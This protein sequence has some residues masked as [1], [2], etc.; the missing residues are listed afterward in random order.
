MVDD[1]ARI[2]VPVDQGRARIHV[3]PAQDIDRKVVLDG[4][5]RDPVEARMVRRAL[6]F[7]RQHDA[8][9]DRARRALPVGDDIAHGGIVRVDRLDDREAA[10]M[11]PLYFHRVTRV[12][13][14][15]GK[16]G[17]EDRAVDPHLVHRRHHL[18]TG[19]VVG[20][21]RHAVPGPLRGVRF[22]SVN[23]GIDDRHRSS[24]SIANGVRYRSRRQPNTSPHN[25]HRQG[26]VALHEARIDALG[27]AHHLDAVEALQ[28]LLP[29]D[30]KLQLGDA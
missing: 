1:E 30:P 25:T 18:I 14:V 5:A 29:D 22:V 10:G 16:G 27:L 3:V 7:L 26:L 13:A 8:D 17:D 6:Y 24:S 4:R 2:G 11:G 28:D 23:L 20:P 9:A 19:D 21:V 12:V 15:H